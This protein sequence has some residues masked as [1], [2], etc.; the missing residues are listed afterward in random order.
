MHKMNTIRVS[1]IAFG[2]L[3][4]ITGI[5]AGVFQIFQ[6]NETLSGVRISYIG[7]G[8]QMWEHDTY[9]ALTLIPNLLYSGIFSLLASASLIYWTLFHLQRKKTGSTGFLLLSIAQLL[10]GGG[11]VIDL[12]F[13]TFL[14]SLGINKDLHRWRSVFNNQFGHTLAV[15]WTPSLIVYSG[16]SIAMIIVTITG[17]NNKVILSVMPILAS[18][19]FIPILLL[20]FGSLASEIRKRSNNLKIQRH[21]N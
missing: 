2:M 15:L 13:I 11:F 6:G 4:G 19:M 3:C 8:Y 14:I 5:V 20:I 7:E 17:I 12:A 21:E 10:S 18:L 1:S 9:F 16:I